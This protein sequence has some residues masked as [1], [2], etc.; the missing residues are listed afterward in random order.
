[1]HTIEG[2]SPVIS[3]FNSMFLRVLYL[4]LLIFNLYLMEYF[5][6][7]VFIVLNNILYL[8]DVLFFTFYFIEFIYIYSFITSV[9]IFIYFIKNYIFLHQ[10]MVS[11]SKYSFQKSNSHYLSLYKI[12]YHIFLYHIIL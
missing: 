11:L 10:I 2:A 5:D 12:N 6:F 1:M 3:K 8:L 7:F 9:S 4:Y